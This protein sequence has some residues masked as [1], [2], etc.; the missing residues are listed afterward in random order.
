V[1]TKDEM[2]NNSKIG[3][4]SSIMVMEP[5]LEDVGW[6]FSCTGTVM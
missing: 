3:D 1:V 2:P 5:W 6:V 4:L